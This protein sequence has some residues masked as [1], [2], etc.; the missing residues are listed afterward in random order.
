METHKTQAFCHNCGRMRLVSVSEADPNGGACLRCRSEIR[1]TA[2][3]AEVVSEGIQ[4]TGPQRANAVYVTHEIRRILEE[5]QVQQQARASSLFREV[6]SLG[7]LQ[8]TVGESVGFGRSNFSAGFHPDNRAAG[9]SLL[10]GLGLRADS[11]DETWPS[12]DTPVEYSMALIGG[13]NSTPL[14]RVVFESEGPSDYELERRSEPLLPL[15][16]YGIANKA[17]IS[18]DRVGW[19]MQG[20]GEVA[21]YNWPY[22]VVDP[23]GKELGRLTPVPGEELL[24]VRNGNAIERVPV[25]ASNYLLVTRVPNFLTPAFNRRVQRTNPG[26]WP[27]VT[28]FGGSHGVGTRGLE[29]LTAGANV[30]VL[31]ELASSIRDAI[32][33]QAMFE[34]SDIDLQKDEGFHRANSIQLLDVAVLDN[35]LD[36]H[37]LRRACNYATRRLGLPHF[38]ELP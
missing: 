7:D 32:A 15:K 33:F 36:D 30:E 29:L 25:L 22:L 3:P 38:W 28:I 9:I 1:L 19:R 8:S 17:R 27:S 11:S 16:Y 12:L 26:G 24:E 21:S 35:Y 34:V 37:T 14:T 6:F 4:T 20:V 31:E 18:D 2:T 13:Q 10:D 5:Q 23:H